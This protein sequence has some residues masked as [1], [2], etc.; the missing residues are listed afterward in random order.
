MK[1]TKSERLK[2]FKIKLSV[3]KIMKSIDNSF[4]RKDLP[5]K[6]YKIINLN[7]LQA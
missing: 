3:I 2:R 7:H 6:P 5:L 1:L 4:Y